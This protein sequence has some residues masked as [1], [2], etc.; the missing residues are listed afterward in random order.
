MPRP[1]ISPKVRSLKPPISRRVG[2]VWYGIAAMFI[3]LQPWAHRPTTLGPWRSILVGRDRVPPAAHVLGEGVGRR[4]AHQTLLGR[5][6]FGRVV[7]HRG[8]DP[9]LLLEAVGPAEAAAVPL[10][11]VLEQV[12]VGLLAATERAVV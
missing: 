1:T 11:R 7:Q 10:E 12:L 9:P 2:N 5:E 3:D 6:G 4:R 8:H